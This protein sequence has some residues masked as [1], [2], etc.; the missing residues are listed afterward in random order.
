MVIPA[1]HAA[2]F[3]I[4]VLGRAL[5]DCS[6]VQQV[7]DGADSRDWRANLSASEPRFV[8]DGCV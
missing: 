4:A 2:R 1:H 8:S 6:R 5:S 3:L 7:A